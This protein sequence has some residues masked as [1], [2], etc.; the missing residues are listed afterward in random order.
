M[1][2]FALVQRQR[3][4][5]FVW[6]VWF[7]HPTPKTRLK[8]QV[9]C[10]CHNQ[11]NTHARARERERERTIRYR[12]DAHAAHGHKDA[13]REAHTAERGQAR[14]RGSATIKRQ[15][16]KPLLESSEEEEEDDEH[17]EDA[18]EEDVRGGRGRGK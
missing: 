1:R 15:V 9:C 8:T 2:T 14:V 11:R 10:T 6:F 4:V 18:D 12:R 16:V 13:K 17:D 7:G 3:F 5:W